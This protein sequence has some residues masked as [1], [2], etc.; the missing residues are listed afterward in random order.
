M[1]Q[2]SQQITCPHCQASI[3]SEDYFCPNCG[4]KIK[5]PPVKMTVFKQIGVYAVS[6]LF[7]PLGLW[8][9]I[10]Y[11]RNKDP[12]IQMVGIV[13]IILTI[14]SSVVTIWY[15]YVLIQNINKTINSQINDINLQNLNNIQ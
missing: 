5:D 7:P 13:A 10:R 8:P 2:T 14:M 6:I 11:F 15:S 4:K 9:G 1:D 3:N 12:K